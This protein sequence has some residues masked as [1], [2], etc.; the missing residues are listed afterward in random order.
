MKNG[1][2]RLGNPGDLRDYLL[3]EPKQYQKAPANQMA[4]KLGGGA[5]SYDDLAA[6]QGWLQNNWQAGV[7]KKEVEDGGFLYAE[8][9]TRFKGQLCLPLWFD[10]ATTGGSSLPAYP[11]NFP[12]GIDTIL[13]V[14]STAGISK[15]AFQIV[16][17][18]NITV[19]AV[20]AMVFNHVGRSSKV[21]I[22]NN[23]SDAP[24]SSLATANGVFGTS[25]AFDYVNHY[26]AQALTSGTA[27][28]VV[29][30]AQSGTIELPVYDH[31][32]TASTRKQWNGSAW[33]NSQYSFSFQCVTLTGTSTG[34]QLA[35][36]Y[37]EEPHFLY[38]TDLYKWNGS[39][40]ALVTAGLNFGSDY[41]AVQFAGKIWIAHDNADNAESWDGA[42]AADLGFKARVFAT[43]NGYLW[44][45]FEN[46]V[47]YTADGT[48]WTGPIQIGPSDYAVMGMAGLDRDMYVST[49]EALYKVAEFDQVFGI[50]RWNSISERNGKGMLHH[51]GAIYIPT[52]SDLLRFGGAELMSVNP[53]KD[54]GLPA[55][56]QGRCVALMS[57][58]YWLFALI[59]TENQAAD[60]AFPL[61]M[62]WNDQ[63]W[64][65]I[66]K[67]FQTDLDDTDVFTSFYWD[68]TN[69][70]LW[71]AGDN[72]LYRYRLPVDHQNPYKDNSGNVK[73]FPGGM[74]ETPWFYGGLKEL[75]KDCESVYIAGENI[76]SARPVRVYWQDDDSTDWELLGTVT[77]NREELRWSDYTTR[78]NTKQIKLAF[79][80]Y[81]DDNTQS[82]R[83]DAIRLKYMTMVHDRFR[84]QLPI[85]VSDGQQMLDGDLNIHTAKQMRSHIDSMVNSVPPV[86]YEDLDGTQYEVKILS[87]VENVQEYRYEDAQQKIVWVYNISIEQ[88]NAG[89][90]SA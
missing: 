67:L 71:V 10:V 6:W 44:R 46:N 27:Y 89:T 90:Y 34:A 57:H 64:H 14:S 66:G 11:S 1:H 15:L 19:D 68:V 51:Q 72:N 61:I 52:Y 53:M 88:V 7:G 45:G 86:I 42:T 4:A 59:T 39:A 60:L 54:E 73:Y 32:S 37:N 41:S 26:V 16:P 35:F 50:N 29:I 85:M 69:D 62:A 58:N 79:V 17:S 3:V 76:S 43:W 21:S 55:S 70:L 20:Y 13:E 77:S 2:I 40:I 30:E 49:T 12:T 63:G 78:P 33:S 47:Y 18:A 25:L 8:L 24:G 84:W 74:L 28:W 22:Y 75:Q 81:T 83:I 48:T 80:L 23:S 87:A 56:K 82:Q 36:N 9:E 5:G 31:G 65:H 38:D